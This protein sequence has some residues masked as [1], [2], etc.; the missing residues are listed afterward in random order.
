MKMGISTYTHIS[1]THTRADTHVHTHTRTQSHTHI[2]T[3]ARPHEKLLGIRRVSN[4][5]TWIDPGSFK[6]GFLLLIQNAGF[7]RDNGTN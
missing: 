7:V 6:I 3:P 4:P 2:H 5:S 1:H